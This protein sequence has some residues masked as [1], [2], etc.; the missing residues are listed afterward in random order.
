MAKR[1]FSVVGS[2]FLDSLLVR[3]KKRTNLL[4]DARDKVGARLHSQGAKTA[5]MNR[6][7]AHALQEVEKRK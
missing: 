5:L 2:L 7:I 4:P 1:D 6:A 3:P